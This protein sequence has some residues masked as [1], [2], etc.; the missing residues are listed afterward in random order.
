M[1]INTL[2]RSNILHILITGRRRT[3]Q[4]LN[5]NGEF[6]KDITLLTPFIW[7]CILSEFYI[8]IITNEPTTLSRTIDVICIIL[9]ANLTAKTFDYR[10]PKNKEQSNLLLVTRF[11][12]LIAIYSSLLYLLSVLVIHQTNG[13]IHLD[14]LH[15]IRLNL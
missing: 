13:I 4:P 2:K 7:A 8:P 11:T 12:A 9:I 1:P 6:R 10:N 5:L 3:D 15:P 14:P